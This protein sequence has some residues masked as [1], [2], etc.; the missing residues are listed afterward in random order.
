MYVRNQ[1]TSQREA[2]RAHLL[3]VEILQV[4]EREHRLEAFPEGLK[5]PGH[6]FVQSPVDHQ[7]GT[8]GWEG[9]RKEKHTVRSQPACGGAPPEV[10]HLTLRYSSR[11]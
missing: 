4:V 11:L 8:G 9:W 1:L 2:I 5:L 6:A 3:R 10:E 7:L